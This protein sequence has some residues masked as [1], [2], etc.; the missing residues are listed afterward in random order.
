M[1]IKD[2][3]TFILVMTA[4]WCLAW[5]LGIFGICK[6]LDKIKQRKQFDTEISKETN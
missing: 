6:L 2:P 5:G 3:V 4:L 1:I